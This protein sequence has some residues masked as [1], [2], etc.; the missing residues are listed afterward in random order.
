[1]ALG[2]HNVEVSGS[3]AIRIFCSFDHTNATN[4]LIFCYYSIIIFLISIE[5]Q[6][7]LRFNV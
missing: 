3:N 5:P 1:M 2:L 6:K 7:G 4:A